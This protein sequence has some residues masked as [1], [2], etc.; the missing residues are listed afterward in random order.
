MWRVVQYS[1]YNQPSLEKFP[2]LFFL[3]RN[4]QRI[5]CFVISSY[6]RILLCA[7]SMRMYRG[8]TYSW[9]GP[10]LKRLTRDRLP[11]YH[12]INENPANQVGSHR[13]ISGVVQSLGCGTGVVHSTHWRL[14]T[15]CPQKV[16][17]VLVL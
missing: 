6:N 14:D 8:V 3:P 5:S 4:V 17:I 1:M 13:V 16:I 7:L 11:S 10:G 15:T 2:S 12:E 9:R